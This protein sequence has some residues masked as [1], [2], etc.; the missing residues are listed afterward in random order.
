[1]LN[2]ILIEATLAPP[3]VD[4]WNFAKGVHYPSGIFGPFGGIHGGSNVIAVGVKF[5]F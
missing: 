2:Y 4:N 3:Q 5:R 1:M